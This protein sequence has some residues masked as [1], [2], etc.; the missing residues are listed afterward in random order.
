MSCAGTA[1]AV[2]RRILSV[3][4]IDIAGHVSRGSRGVY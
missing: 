4:N 1:A 3:G 2:E